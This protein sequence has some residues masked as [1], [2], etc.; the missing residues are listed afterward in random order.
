MQTANRTLHIYGMDVAALNGRITRTTP[1]HVSSVQI[2]S[3]PPRLLEHHKSITLCF[4]IFY[5]DGLMFFTTESRNIHFIT[6]E[7]LPSRNIQNSVLPCLQRV[8]HLYH[9]CGFKIEHAHANKEFASMKYP[10]FKMRIWLNVAATSEH[11]P[12]VERIIRTIKE[13]NHTRAS[14]IP[15]KNFLLTL[16][17]ALIAHAVLCLNFLPHNNGFSDSMSPRAIITGDALTFDLHCRVSMRS[18]C[19]V[20]DD[21]HPSNT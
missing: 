9:A 13:R 14:M 8:T 12:E 19:E 2:L 16:K 6:V 17:C 20:H 4:D 11:V 15:Y 7:H 21:P 3:L 10:H 18:Y 1:D 5:F